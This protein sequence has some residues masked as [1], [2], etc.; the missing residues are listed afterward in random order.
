MTKAAFLA[1]DEETPVFPG[2]AAVEEPA[3]PPADG[4]L[5]PWRGGPVFH[6]GHRSAVERE[7]PDF[8]D[9]RVPA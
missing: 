3:G 8:W 1:E 5:P 4:E 6:R 9:D 7:D 2:P